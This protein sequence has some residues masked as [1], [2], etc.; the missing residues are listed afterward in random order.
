MNRKIKYEYWYIYYD[1]DQFH[2]YKYNPNSVLATGPFTN[3]KILKKSILEKM[4][5]HKKYLLEQINYIKKL[6]NEDCI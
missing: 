1:F 3:I 4:L 5:N 2:I 6:K